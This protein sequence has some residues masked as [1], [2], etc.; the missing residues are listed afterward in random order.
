MLCTSLVPRL[1]FCGGGK[2][3]FF[4]S[5]A[6]KWP[7]YEASYMYMSN[8]HISPPPPPPHAYT[9]YYYQLYFKAMDEDGT[10]DA[11]VDYSYYNFY[12]PSKN[13][14]YYTYM[15]GRSGGT[16][17]YLYVRHKWYI[18]QPTTT[19]PTARDTASSQTILMDIT[20]VTLTGTRFV[21]MGGLVP[22]PTVR[23]V[24][25]N[26]INTARKTLTL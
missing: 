19:R 20:H 24:R 5:P 8:T 25:D 6:K 23:Q 10:Y 12:Y 1:F 15:Y 21:L 13:Y 16:N 3:G 17:V 22:R 14:N 7:G 11:I 18:V 4:P 26:T 9:Q 2:K